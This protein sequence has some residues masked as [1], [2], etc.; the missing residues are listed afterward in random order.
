MKKHT[1]LFLASNPDGT[2]RLALDKEAQAIQV[3]LERAGQRDRFELVTRWAAEPLDLLRELGKL[4]PTV[5]HFSGHGRSPAREKPS[6]EG[7]HRDIEVPGQ[8]DQS[9]LYFR[10]R[11]GRAQAVSTAAFV[12]TFGAAGA[13][14]KLV[15]LNACYSEVQAEAL[16]EY[17]DY[18]V[19]MA[20]TMGDDAARAFAVGF[21]CGLG[22]SE[23]VDGAYKYGCAAINVEGLPEWDR[24]QL[25][26]RAGVNANSLVLAADP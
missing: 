9:G 14:V 2:D 1:I 7:P 22:A 19:G 8:G 11:D 26:M 13:S 17:V 24:P 20:G 4:R 6:G 16:I 25:K 5:V 12:Q 21:Y 23:P 3:E 18:V 10:G 15:V